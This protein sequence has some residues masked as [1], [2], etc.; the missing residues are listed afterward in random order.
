MQLAAT[1]IITDDVDAL[2]AFYETATGIT[3]VRLHPMFA[4]LRT[5]SGTLAIA[6]SATVP[7]LGDNAAEARAN[8]SI[9]LDFLVNDVDATY[10]AL[11]G[12]VGIFVNEPTDMPWGNRSLLVRDPDGT[13]INFFTPITDA[14][15]DRF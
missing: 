10:L 14:G 8:R 15:R 6:S 3:A 5:T 12:V 13:L 11:Q 2:I 9:T 4:E 1:R 7:L